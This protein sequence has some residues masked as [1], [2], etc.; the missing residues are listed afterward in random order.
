MPPAVT[1][2]G[3]VPQSK[4]ALMFRMFR[5]PLAGL[6]LASLIAGCSAP[7]RQSAD[8]PASTDAPISDK[9]TCCVCMPPR[10]PG[11]VSSPRKS[12]AFWH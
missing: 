2:C 11:I 5:L 6:I 12:G 8:L 1:L 3:K 4:V 7:R 10:L 9:P